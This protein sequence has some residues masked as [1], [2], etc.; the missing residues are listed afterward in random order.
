ML[1]D[2]TLC[3]FFMHSSQRADTPARQPNG[4]EDQAIEMHRPLFYSSSPRSEPCAGHRRVAGVQ[5]KRICKHSCLS[6][7]CLHA[8]T[9]A[10]THIN[11]AVKS[12]PIISHLFTD[13]EPIGAE[14]DHQ[15]RGEWFCVTVAIFSHLQ[16]HTHFLILAS[17]SFL[18][19]THPHLCPASHRPLFSIPLFPLLFY[20]DVALGII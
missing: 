9:H 7:R 12:K 3:P 14:V 2:L 18:P 6:N 20:T 13:I 17:V 1:F 10:H 11:K 16:W 8:H 19:L 15:P 4:R 5:R